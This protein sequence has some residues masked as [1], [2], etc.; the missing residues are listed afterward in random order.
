M[1]LEAAYNTCAKNLLPYAQFDDAGAVTLNVLG[2]Q[3]VQETTAAADHLVHA[4]TAVIVLFMDFQMGGELV[5][6]LGENSDLHLGRT[7]IIFASAV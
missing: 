2:H 3:V 1:R 5:Y 6:T 7:S 4:K